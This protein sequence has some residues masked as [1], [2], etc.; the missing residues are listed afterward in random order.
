MAGADFTLREFLDWARTKPA[1][2]EYAVWT[3]GRCALGQ[4]GTA[5]GRTYLYSCYNPES[6]L[7]I[8][9]LNRALGFSR[10]VKQTFGA[11]AKRLE[12]L[13]PASSDTWTK[14]DAYLTD[15]EQVDA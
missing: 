14:L 8:V 11:L 9:G 6:Q 12:A 5:T 15:I 4:F 1:D 3:A 13:I 2:E 7:G 10:E